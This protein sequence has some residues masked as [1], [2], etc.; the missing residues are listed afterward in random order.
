M[1]D[2]TAETRLG[3]TDY[4]ASIASEGSPE[5]MAQAPTTTS[6]LAAWWAPVSGDGTEGGEL[7]F[8]MHAPEGPLVIKVRTAAQ[9][10]V[11][12][13]D[14]LECPFLPDWEATR[15][16]FDIGRTESGGCE[17]FFR[18]HGL[19]PE[20]ECFAM[21]RRGW[22]HFIPSLAQ[23]VGTGTG[24]PLGSTADNARRSGQSS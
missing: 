8:D 14:V 17:L 19:T 23:Y 9:P 10:H 4:T 15:I 24:N 20:L 2:P 5:K 3:A 7:R 18:H 6:G 21:C 11:V 16:T 22:D 1:T 12:V 13:W